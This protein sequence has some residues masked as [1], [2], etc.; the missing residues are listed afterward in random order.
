MKTLGWIT[1]PHFNFLKRD[2]FAEFVDELVAAPI[3]ALLLGG[4][5]AEALSVIPFLTTL[6]VRLPYPI[7]FVLGN[8]DYYHGSIAHT[9]KA[10]ARWVQDSARTKWLAQSD[11]LPLTESTALVGHGGWGDGRA[12]DFANSPI[13]LNDYRYIKELVEWD[14]A[15]LGERLAALGDEAADHLEKALSAALPRFSEVLVLTHVPPFVEAC[16]HEG[17]ISDTQWSPHFTCLA[18]GR[19]LLA[20]ADAHPDHRIHVLC[21]HTHGEGHAQLRPNL[22]VSTGGAQYGAPALQKPII[23][24]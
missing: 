21:G 11:V 10:V 9:R 1:D 15:A 5:L 3:E 16:W 4:D 13:M 24:R 8:H 23:V 19:V 2:K 7:Y 22:T 20:A 6:D 17:Q 12:G 18:T 14:R